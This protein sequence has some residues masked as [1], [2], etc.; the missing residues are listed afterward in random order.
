MAAPVKA[1][2]NPTA[3]SRMLVALV[4]VPDAP[5]QVQRSLV[6]PLGPLLWRPPVLA[7]TMPPT[8]TPEV[9]RI[10]PPPMGKLMLSTFPPAYKASTARVGQ[11]YPRGLR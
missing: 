1:Y 10:P 5:V 4:A 7:V 11:I 9:P 8:L 2:T 6:L 3:I